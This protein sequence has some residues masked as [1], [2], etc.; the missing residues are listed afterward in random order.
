MSYSTALNDRSANAL[1]STTMWGGKPCQG[2]AAKRLHHQ[3]MSHGV[4]VPYLFD[5]IDVRRLQWRLDLA[6]L[7][8]LAVRE[9]EGVTCRVRGT[10][11]LLQRRDSAMN[12]QAK[13]DKQSQHS[14]G[15]QHHMKHTHTHTHSQKIDGEVARIDKATASQPAA[16]QRRAALV[17]QTTPEPHIYSARSRHDA[18]NEAIQSS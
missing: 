7:R 3:C 1:P 10:R 15:Q 16:N 12:L 4:A 11:L 9:L 14:H 17:N 6:S 13:Y 2:E 5:W 8:Q 18:G